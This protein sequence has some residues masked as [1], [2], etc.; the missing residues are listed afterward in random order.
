MALQELP[1]GIA[2]LGG[3][4]DGY[5][6]LR[7]LLQ[8]RGDGLALLAD[9]AMH[10]FADGLQLF[11][12][13]HAGRV[14]AADAFR[15]RAHQPGHANEEKLVQVRADDGQELDPLHQRHIIGQPLTEHAVVELQPT[16]LAVEIHAG[17]SKRVFAHVNSSRTFIP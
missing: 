17:R 4:D 15:P 8:G 3:R 12:G 2:P 1:L 13:R 14:A 10:P 6:L 7:Q 11:R 5:P 9:H 16:Q